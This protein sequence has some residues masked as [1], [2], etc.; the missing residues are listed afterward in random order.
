MIRLRKIAALKIIANRKL[1]ATIAITTAT[2]K[3]KIVR[4]MRTR[5]AKNHFYKKMESFQPARKMSWL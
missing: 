2:T 5:R 1:V 4:A 3:H